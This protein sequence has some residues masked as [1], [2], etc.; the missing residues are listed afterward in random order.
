MK[1][2]LESRPPTGSAPVLVV[3]VPWVRC[4]GPVRAVRGVPEVRR[5]HGVLARLPQPWFRSAPPL[6]IDPGVNAPAPASASGAAAPAASPA[7]DRRV[8]PGPLPAGGERQPDPGRPPPRSGTGRCPACR[9][10]NA[11]PPGRPREV[12]GDECGQADAEVDVG[13]VGELGDGDPA[14]HRG[15]S[16]WPGNSTTAPSVMHWLVRCARCLPVRLMVS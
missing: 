13:A 2:S 12:A 7:A 1:G 8:P 5:C 6:S 16:A 15:S 9:S 11:G 10:P 4:G 3:L 14:G